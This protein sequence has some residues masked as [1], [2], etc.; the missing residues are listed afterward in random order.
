[1]VKRL[2]SGMLR[3]CARAPRAGD[4]KGTMLSKTL[5]EDDDCGELQQARYPCD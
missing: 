5:L 4:A 3:S 1:M 2:V